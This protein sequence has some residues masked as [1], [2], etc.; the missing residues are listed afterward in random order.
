M[1]PAGRDTAV[2]LVAHGTVE[3]LDDL[4][5]FLANIRRG[6]AAPPEL[7]AEVRRRYEAIGG[8]SPLLDVT[9][10]VAA[11]LEAK[12]GLP[13]RV[14]MR[15]FH[16]YPKDVLAE[17]A[18]EGIRRVVTVPLAQHS[19]GVYGSAVQAAAN[20]VDPTLEVLAAPNWGRTPELTRAFAASVVG[21]LARVPRGEAARTALVLTAHSLPIS[22]V[23]AGD[24]YA[25]EFRASVEDI[26]AEVRARAGGA[27][28]EHAVAFQSQGIGTGV[29]WLGPDLRATLEALSARG[30][31]HVVVAPVGFL[32]DH[33]EILYDLDIEAKAWCEGELGIVLYRS[34][35]LNA[36]D[37]IVDA[38]AAVT[39]DVLARSARAG[40]GSSGSKKGH[41]RAG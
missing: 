14:A 13:T 28:A 40:G 26:V 18:A 1:T 16:P 24:P 23:R 39:R 15:L 21:A 27:F 19:A 11:K 8:R 2:V 38:L 22:V 5:E 33:V 17:L 37:G 35:S 20:A 32:A 4:P 30:V 3:S 10:E 31:A 34:A 29:E 41:E 6:Q 7:V 36:G 9:R 12:L 25:D